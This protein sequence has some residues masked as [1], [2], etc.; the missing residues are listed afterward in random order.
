MANARALTSASFMLCSF[1]LG[2]CR[3]RVA[4][5][6][7]AVDGDVERGDS[8]LIRRP[9][10]RFRMA[11]RA[12][13]VVISGVPMVD[14]AGAGKLVV[15]GLNLIVLRAIDQMHDLVDVAIR[16]GLEKLDVLGVA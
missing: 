16:D 14:H 4:L 2:G 1:G 6:F 11:Q 15:L 8:G 10:Q 3:G 5:S 12:D 9:L 7:A 13:R